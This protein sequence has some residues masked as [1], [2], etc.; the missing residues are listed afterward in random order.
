VAAAE[1]QARELAARARALL[2]DWG[3]AADPLRR[4][5][6]LMVERRR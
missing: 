5:T 2:A 4:L 6:D 1:A 3:V